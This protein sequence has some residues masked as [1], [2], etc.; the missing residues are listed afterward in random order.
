MDIEKLKG[1]W[2]K[3]TSSL[4]NMD[5]KDEEDLKKILIRRSQKSLKILRRNFF[6]EAGLNIL[7][8]PLILVFILSTDFADKPFNLI[9][10]GFVVLILIVF[11][12]YLYRS[13]KNIYRYEYHGL[14]L[15]DKLKEQIARLEKFI[16]DYYIFLYFTYFMALVL[17][18]FSE[19][20][21]DIGSFLIRFGIGIALGLGLFFLVLRPFAKFYI[22]K[23]YGYHLKSLKNCLAELE[24]S[25]DKN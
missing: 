20:P 5:Y 10:S 11:L 6:I 3:Y 25:I 24:D 17:G 14:H 23:L 7:I 21:E 19:L 13:Y 1:S 18:L 8:V 9:F 15:K 2:K 4:S 16:K 22:R 12:Y